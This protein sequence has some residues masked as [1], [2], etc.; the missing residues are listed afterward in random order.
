MEYTWGKTKA[1]SVVFKKYYTSKM[2]LNVNF[3]QTKRVTFHYFI[4]LGLLEF[5]RKG[6]KISLIEGPIIKTFH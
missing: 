1:V 3:Y 4:F 2:V 5:Q 6:F